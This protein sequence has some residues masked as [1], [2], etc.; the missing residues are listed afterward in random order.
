MNP[1][2]PVVAFP[3]VLFAVKKMRVRIT[4]REKTEGGSDL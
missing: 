3:Y 2:E 4:K 1:I